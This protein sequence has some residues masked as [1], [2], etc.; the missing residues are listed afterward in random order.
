MTSLFALK[1]L[2][3]KIIRNSYLHKYIVTSQTD[4]KHM[5][6]LILHEPY[7]LYTLRLKDDSNILIENCFHYNTSS[8]NEGINHENTN[9]TSDIRRLCLV[10]IISWALLQIRKSNENNSGCLSMFESDKKKLSRES[11]QESEKMCERRITLG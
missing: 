5:Y 4:N 1:H 9:E 8:L 11:T 7:A 3:N 6:C 10:N 2:F